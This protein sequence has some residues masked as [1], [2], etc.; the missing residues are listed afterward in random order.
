[1]AYGIFESNFG[2]SIF[3]QVINFSSGNVFMF[4]FYLFL[5][6]IARQFRSDNR[7]HDTILRRDGCGYGS[8]RKLGSEMD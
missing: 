6:I 2:L 3:L 4:L 7:L 8:E 5:I 1:M